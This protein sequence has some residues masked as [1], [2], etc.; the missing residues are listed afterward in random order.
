ME[1]KVF[2]NRY[3]LSL[4]R[5]G[6]PIELRRTP[7]GVTYRAHEI[8]SGREAALELIPVSEL[9]PAIVESI[10]NEASALGQIAHLNFPALYD[11]GIEEGQLIYATEYCDGPTAQAWVTARGPLAPGA[12]LRIALQVVD[13]L[14]AA[15]FHRLSHPA[16]SPA[17]IIFIPGQTAKGDW[18]AIKVLHWLGAPA[19]QVALDTAGNHL[20]AEMP[21]E[22][23]E[24]REGGKADFPSAIY[25]LGGTMWFLL[26]GVVPS[27]SGDKIGRAGGEK[28]RGL[29][30]IVR[31][32][33]ERMLRSN[34]AERPQ[35]PV[36]L[37]AYLQTCLARV[38]RRENIE[39]RFG[40]AAVPTPRVVKRRTPLVFPLKPLALAAILLALAASAG[41]ILPWPLR[42]RKPAPVAPEIVLVPPASPTEVPIVVKDT[43]GRIDEIDRPAV[44]PSI[45]VAN[46]AV[47]K[48]ARE[49]SPA[50]SGAAPSEVEPA[51]PAEGPIEPTENF[52]PPT[53][54]SAPVFGSTDPVEPVVDAVEAG[55][56]PPHFADTNES[57]V[58][59]PSVAPAPEEVTAPSVS[60]SS[61]QTVAKAAPSDKEEPSTAKKTLARRTHRS[62][63]SRSRTR[64]THGTK[65]AKPLPEL[66]VGS[67]PAELVGT[68]ADGR[69]ILSVSESGRRLIVPPPPG[70]GQ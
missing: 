59:A 46:P 41:L 13:A 56:T 23:P 32:L 4:G 48:L 5:N 65:R 40:V 7:A 69:W 29:P 27:L 17:N 62:S 55:D 63:Q 14:G 70:Y 24:Q 20:G 54:A 25:A 16:L 47:T 2:L 6:L 21:Y 61:A 43:L 18:P 31:H 50:R 10:Q 51:P 57:S 60:E 66:R 33:L 36:A 26:T 37:G 19:E 49:K 34:P 1:T 44:A 42:H 52:D 68:T 58:A 9:D 15:S 11:F 22:S 30:K 38:E 28:L 39:R 12:V 45:A 64:L 35:D 8:A 3:R 53:M 67:T